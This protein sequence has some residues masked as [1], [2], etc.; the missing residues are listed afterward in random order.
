MRLEKKKKEK[1]K[2]TQKQP[3]LLIGMEAKRSKKSPSVYLFNI[4]SLSQITDKQIRKELISSMQ[5]E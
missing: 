2:K 1:H 3:Y 5:F 4:Q